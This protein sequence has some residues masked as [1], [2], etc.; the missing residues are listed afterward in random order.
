[1]AGFSL[2]RIPGEVAVA[3]D[4]RGDMLGWYFRN[5]HQIGVKVLNTVDRNQPD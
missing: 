4:L 3:T 2:V 1:M 5:S